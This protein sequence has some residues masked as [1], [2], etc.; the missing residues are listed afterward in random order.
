MSQ[1]L[2]EKVLS[3]EVQAAGVG[4]R[5]AA[6]TPANASDFDDRIRT[7]LHAAAD[8]KAIDLTVLEV[9]NGF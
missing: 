6:P 8:K 7:A 2:K 4:R 9:R 1:N 3:S 5:S